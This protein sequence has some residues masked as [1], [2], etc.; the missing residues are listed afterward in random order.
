MQMDFA[1]NYAIVS[2]DEIQSAHWSHSQVTLFTCCVWFPY[3]HCS[4]YVL[5]SNDMSHSKYS[6]YTF[7]KALIEDVRS[8][9]PQINKTFILSDNCAQQFKTKYTLS[10]LCFF[11]KDFNSE[12]ECNF[13]AS[14]HGKGAM[15]GIGN[16]VKRNVWTAVK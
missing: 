5:V 13:F 8:V 1:E 3:K 4:S 14:S 16:T 15:D 12:V 7:I 10:N 11:E 2:Q 6:V 9:Y